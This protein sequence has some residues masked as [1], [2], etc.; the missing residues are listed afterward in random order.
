MKCSSPW[1]FDG[2]SSTVFMLQS[3]IYSSYLCSHCY[4]WSCQVVFF[5]CSLYRNLVFP[6]LT[7]REWNVKYYFSTAQTRM[8]PQ[9]SSAVCTH[10]VTNSFVQP[11]LRPLFFFFSVTIQTQLCKKTCILN[12]YLE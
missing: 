9:G 2:N 7:A 11:H 6:W 4:E 10:L 5:S 3:R 1:K 8:S 12:M